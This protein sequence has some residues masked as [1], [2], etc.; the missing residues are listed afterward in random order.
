[1]AKSK[2]TPRKGYKP[3][4]PQSPDDNCARRLQNLSWEISVAGGQ[5]LREHFGF[6][7]EQASQWLELLAKQ[8]EANRKGK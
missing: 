3:V 6:T 4:F 8:V 1:M 2:H 5:V 7:A